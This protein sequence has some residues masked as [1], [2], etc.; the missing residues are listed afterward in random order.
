MRKRVVRPPEYSVIEIDGPDGSTIYSAGPEQEGGGL[1]IFNETWIEVI[2]KPESAWRQATRAKRKLDN[3]L[4]L[5]SGTW[6]AWFLLT[7][8]MVLSREAIEES[9][10]EMSGASTLREAQNHLVSA[11]KARAMASDARRHAIMEALSQGMDIHHELAVSDWAFTSW[12]E[13]QMIMRADA[14]DHHFIERVNGYARAAN[15]L[16]KGY[17]SEVLQFSRALEKEASRCRKPPDKEKV[18]LAIGRII[19]ADELRAK[20]LRA[21]SGEVVDEESLCDSECDIIDPNTFTRLLK[22]AGFG[23]L[24]NGKPGP[25]RQTKSGNGVSAEV[26]EVNLPKQKLRRSSETS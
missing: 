24:P 7:R 23:W 16:Q 26:I 1:L 20:N 13:D 19:K 5:D 11:A 25:R 8:A 17:P 3:K 10:R 21:Y 14:N 18:R 2:L 9:K 4:I 12:F 15:G 22:R 6:N